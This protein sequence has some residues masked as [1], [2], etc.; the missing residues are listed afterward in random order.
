MSAVQKEYDDSSTFMKEV[1]KESRQDPLGSCDDLTSQEV[2]AG[3]DRRSFLMR[4]AVGGAAAVMMGRSV[5]ASE[6]T[7]KAIA[8]LP[9]LPQAGSSPPLAKD[10]EVVKKG[11]GPVLT[12]AE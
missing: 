5:S 2:P 6:R 1:D 11:H 9:V 7:A 10:L 3:V 4:S 12:T 8:T